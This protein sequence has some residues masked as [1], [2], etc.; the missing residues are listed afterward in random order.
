MWRTPPAASPMAPAAIS[1]CFLRL[2]FGEERRIFI[3]ISTVLSVANAPV[4]GPYTRL[5][6]LRRDRPDRLDHRRPGEGNGARAALRGA[7]RDLRRARQPP[8]P[9]DRRRR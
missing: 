1:A 9:R 4:A 2:R 7:A 6:D 5:Q 3:C 8:L